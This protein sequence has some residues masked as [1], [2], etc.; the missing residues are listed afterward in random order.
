MDIFSKDI[1]HKSVETIIGAIVDEGQVFKDFKIVGNMKGSTVVLRFCLPAMLQSSEQVRSTPLLTHK[2]PVNLTRDMN[3]KQ[4]WVN[5]R[6]EQ[7]EW[8]HTEANDL[9]DAR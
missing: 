8:K 9:F 7:T 6:G 1:I 2:S 4:E 3:R 5:T